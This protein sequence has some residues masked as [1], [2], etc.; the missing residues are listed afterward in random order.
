M[1]DSN[2]GGLCLTPSLCYKKSNTS[3]Y[4]SISIAEH[5]YFGRRIF[6]DNA[7]I[8]SD[9]FVCC[10]DLKFTAQQ[11]FL[12]IQ[13]TLDTSN[14]QGTEKSSSY[15]EFEFS[16]SEFKSRKIIW[17]MLF[18]VYFKVKKNETK[19]KLYKIVSYWSLL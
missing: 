6:L 3:V 7:I 9:L 15:R 11:C 19:L 2:K 16:R 4:L 17:L 1:F 5:D 10:F 18:D 8:K 13:Y 14:C 12:D